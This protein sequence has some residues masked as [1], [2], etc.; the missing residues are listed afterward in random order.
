MGMNSIQFRDMTVGEIAAR[1][2]GATAIFR[3]SGIDFCCGGNVSLSEAARQRGA[4]LEELEEALATL[5]LC[6]PEVPQGTSA[7][8]D[9]ILHRFHEKHRRD[10]PELIKLAKKVEAVHR[11][12]EKVP[13]GLAMLLVQ[14][15]QELEAHMQK[16]EQILFPSMVA[17]YSGGLDMPIF[18]M[19]KEHEEHAGI[20][21]ELE[22]VTSGFSLPGGA[23][24][25]W[26]ALYAGTECFVY[27][28]KEHIHL[29]NNM[30]FP[31]FQTR[32]TL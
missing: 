28:L 32:V 18:V 4:N 12:H 20:I 13:K 27:E 25:S 17:N 10:I 2:G 23:C 29:E 15:Q 11:E 16:E 8:V 24:R 7:L 9:Y 1:L 19:R 21:R 14:A 30:L 26:Q 6:P 31:R 5:N 22:Q 3:K